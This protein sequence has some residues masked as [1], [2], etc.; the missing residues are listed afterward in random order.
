MPI[1]K[2]APRVYRTTYLEPKLDRKLT[3]LAQNKNMS[4][5]GLIRDYIEQGLERDRQSK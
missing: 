1:R 3:K 2:Q 5:A 4:V